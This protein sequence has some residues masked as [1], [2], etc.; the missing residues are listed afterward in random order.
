LMNDLEHAGVPRATA[1]LQLH[2]GFTFADAA[3][4]VPY[5]A[6]LGISHLYLSP[7]T[8]ARP[9]STHGYDVTDCTRINPELGGEP[10]FRAL[11]ETVQAAGLGVVLDIVPNHMAASATHNLWWRDVLAH[12]RA[13]AYAGHFDIEWQSRDPQL[14]GK[15]LLPILGD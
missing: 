5:H 7:I 10:G 4:V 2:A 11:C 3:A 8:C 6:A 12:G 15:V 9:G 1:R 14:Q 13:S